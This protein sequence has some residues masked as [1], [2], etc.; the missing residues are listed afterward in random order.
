MMKRT[1]LTPQTSVLAL[2]L[3]GLLMASGVQ[4]DNKGIG[5]GGVDEEGGKDPAAR[6]R[7]DVWRDDEADDDL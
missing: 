5:Y 6:R 7:H 4:N 1:Y 3:H 2:S